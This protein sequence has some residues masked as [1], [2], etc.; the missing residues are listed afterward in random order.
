MHSPQPLDPSLIREQ[1]RAALAEDLGS[2]DVT[3]ALLPADQQARAELITRESAVL[4]GRDWFAAV[5]HA[6]DPAI[7]IDWEAAD[8]ARV[9]P[10]QRL[11]VI[12]GPVRA[13]LT[14]ERTAMNLLQTLSGTATRTR[15]FADAVAGLPVAVLD[16]RK[17]LPGLRLQQ[18]YAVRCG[19]GTNH[20]MGLHDA[21]L[22]KENHI[23]AAGSIAAAVTAAQALQTGLEIIVEVES[24]AE[25][26]QALAAG[27]PTVLLDNFDNDQLREAVALNAGRARLEAS[28]GVNLETIRAIAETGVDRISVGAL[29][30]DVTAVDLSMRLEVA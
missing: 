10:G 9:A 17:T 13:L 30:K 26:E 22:I 8:G 6:L 25:L 3:A 2:G 27:A 12:T 7:R 11:C 4:C 19:G 14:G 28:G 15:R 18:K 23:L 5:F 29:T 21:I 16:T 24:L 1:A 20:R